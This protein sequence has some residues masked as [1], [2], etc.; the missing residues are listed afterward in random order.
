MTIKTE[1][2]PDLPQVDQLIEISKRLWNHED[3]IAIW[4][5]GSFG[6]GK[7]DRYS[8]VDLRVAVRDQSLD[9]WKNPDFEA[10]FCRPAVDSTTSVRTDDAVLHHVLLNNAEMYDLWVQTPERELNPE[11]KL[12]IGC[13]DDQ[14][15]ERLARPFA[16]HMLEFEDVQPIQI[17]QALRM[18]WSNHVKHEKVIHRNLTLML[19]DAIYLFSGILLR[20]KFIQAKD[21]DCGIVTF[22][23]MTI[24]TATPLLKILS[25][26]YGN[27]LL[28]GM[29]PSTWS[30]ADAVAAIDKLDSEIAATGRLLVDKYEFDYPYELERVV[31]ESWK[32]FKRYEP[33]NL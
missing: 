23:P 20:L 24:H 29:L 19:R 26:E 33:L 8:D 22:P 18:Y 11:P 31:L 5:G 30:Q 1:S 27:D 21:K 25:D 32:Q 10:I 2:L 4:L 28:A 7:A 3:T 16:E 14:F 9:W 13:R 6:C 17:A 15:R 12:I